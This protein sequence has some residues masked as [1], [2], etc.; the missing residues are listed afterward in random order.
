MKT[1]ATG[2]YGTNAKDVAHWMPMMESSGWASLY[3]T[4]FYILLLLLLFGLVVYVYLW[5]FKLW[6]SMD[7]R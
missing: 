7:K 1:M 2:L 6:K 5:I 3:M 4:V